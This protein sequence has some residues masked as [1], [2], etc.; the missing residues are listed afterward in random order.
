MLRAIG[1]RQHERQQLVGLAGIPP[2]ARRVRALCASSR[3]TMSNVRPTRCPFSS[4][5][6][7]TRPV[8]TMPMRSGQ[9]AMCFGPLG[10]IAYSSG[11]SQTLRLECQRAQ[12]V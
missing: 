3:T 5:G 11:S 4:D 8:E 2:A 1:D 12:P 9:R 10:E 7:T 6:C